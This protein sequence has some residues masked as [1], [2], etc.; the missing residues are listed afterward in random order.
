MRNS[1]ATSA[2]VSRRVFLSYAHNDQRIADRL[3]EYLEAEGL[4]IYYPGRLRAGDE[5]E[6]VLARAVREATW[7]VVLVSESSV[8]SSYQDFELGV[9]FGQGKRVIPIWLSSTAMEKAP[10]ALREIQGVLLRARPNSEELHRVA[11]EVAL[12]IDRAAGQSA[13]YRVVHRAGKWLVYGEDA[14]R[15]SGTFA[16]KAEA[17]RRATGLAQNQILGEILVYTKAGTVQTRLAFGQNQR[18]S[19]D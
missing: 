13:T 15:P 10:P 5:W 7:F 14:T 17:V 9:G 4:A 16:T 2:E 6:Q 11:R 8:R 3:A 12:T 19:T 18:V 1:S